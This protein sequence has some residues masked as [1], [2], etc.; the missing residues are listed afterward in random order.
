M[1]RKKLENKQKNL[2][3][4]GNI[5]I[6]SMGN[7]LESMISDS[8]GR[9]PYIIIYDCSNNNYK[10]FENT[11]AKVQDG[12]GIEA[13]DIILKSNVKILLTKEIGKKAYSVLM[14]GNVEIHLLKL[15]STVKY[16]INRFVKKQRSDID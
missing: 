14:K 4:I 5:A 3:M 8:L 1:L 15:T 11:G 12:A 13:S 6:P 2:R 7:I 9:A 10:F 16:A